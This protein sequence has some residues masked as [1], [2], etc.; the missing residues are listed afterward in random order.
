M[1]V[2][3]CVCVYVCVY[4]CVCVVCVC[5]VCDVCACECVYVCIRVCGGACMCVVHVVVCIVWVRL[6]GTRVHVCQGVGRS[7]RAYTCGNANKCTHAQNV[8]IH[9]CTMSVSVRACTCVHMCAS[10]HVFQKC[11][12]ARGN[13]G[14]AQKGDLSRCWQRGRDR[15]LVTVLSLF[16]LLHLHFKR[17]GRVRRYSAGHTL[18]T[19]KKKSAKKRKL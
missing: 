3:V 4:V 12:C 19:R 13:R 5:G 18:P 15:R 10:V 2:C 1:C 6:C 17:Q 8:C 14:A 16:G 9:V 11:M 7:T